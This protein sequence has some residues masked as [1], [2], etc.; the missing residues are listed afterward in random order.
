V[1]YNA[2]GQI[3][4]NFSN[5]TDRMNTVENGNNIQLQYDNARPSEA[6]RCCKLTQKQTGALLGVLGVGFVVAGAAM[7]SFRGNLYLISGQDMV[8][9]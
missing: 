5:E 3:Y 7:Y 6:Y 8:Y 4:T 2:G 1:T 9:T